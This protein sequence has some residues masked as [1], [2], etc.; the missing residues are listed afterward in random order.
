MQFQVG[1]TSGYCFEIA[2]EQRPMKRGVT[3]S[4]GARGNKFLDAA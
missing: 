2:G 1:N 4:P 3:P